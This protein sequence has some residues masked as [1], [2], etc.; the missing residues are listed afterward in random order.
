METVVRLKSVK[1]SWLTNKFWSSSFTETK[2]VIDAR[3]L[4]PNKHTA[5]LQ[6]RVH[7]NGSIT[8]EPLEEND[9]RP[10]SHSRNLQPIRQFL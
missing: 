1:P 9:P 6:K 10:P 3:E 4:L 8:Y 7:S 5:G 2:R